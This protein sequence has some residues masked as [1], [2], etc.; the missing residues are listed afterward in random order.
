M[1]TIATAAAAATLATTP[2][3]VQ[4]VEGLLEGAVDAEDLTGIESC[5]TDV[6]HDV[7][8]IESTYNDCKEKSVLARAKCAKDISTLLG[9]VKKLETDCTTGVKADWEKIKAMEK[10]FASPA[11]FEYHVLQDVIINHAAIGSEIV[12]AEAAYKSQDWLNFGKNIGEAA[13]KVIL[14]STEEELAFSGVQVKSEETGVFT[15]EQFARVLQGMLESYGKKIDVLALLE[16][17]QNEDKALLAA[18]VGW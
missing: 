18:S 5:V 15:K 9:D 14:G 7:K 10:I 17:V 4:I 16:C 11:A 6:E 13:A 2:K 1:Q 8:D 3:W 12:A